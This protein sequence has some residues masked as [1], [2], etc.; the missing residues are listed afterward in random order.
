MTL[1]TKILYNLY[2]AVVLGVVEMLKTYFFY[3]AILIFM[4]IT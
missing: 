4:L 1:N 3:S 2:M